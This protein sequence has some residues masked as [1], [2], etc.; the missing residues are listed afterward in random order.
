MINQTAEIG[1]GVRT[2]TTLDL[3]TRAS[4]RRRPFASRRRRRAH[5]R[6]R[7]RAVPRLRLGFAYKARIKKDTLHIK[8]NI[9]T[10]SAYKAHK[11]RNVCKVSLFSSALYAK[12][13]Y[14]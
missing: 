2:R 6:A 5:A 9:N 12:C 10:E 1:V 13:P 4:R 7:A 8:H 14:W 11:I 3:S